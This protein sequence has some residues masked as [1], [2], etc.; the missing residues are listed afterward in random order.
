VNSRIGEFKRERRERKERREKRERRERRERR[1]RQQTER[2]SETER[3][4]LAWCR[5]GSTIERSERR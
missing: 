4:F 2:D 5:Q 3:R 1:D